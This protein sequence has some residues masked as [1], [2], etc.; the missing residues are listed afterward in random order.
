MVWTVWPC[1]KRTVLG[2]LDLCEGSQAG[3]WQCMV[4]FCC[5]LDDMAGASAAVPA[6]CLVIFFPS[7]TSSLFRI[8]WCFQACQG[9]LDRRLAPIEAW[10]LHL[11]LDFSQRC[12]AVLKLA[13]V[14]ASPC[15]GS[16]GLHSAAGETCYEACGRA[17]CLLLRWL[18]P[19]GFFTDCSMNERALDAKDFDELKI[20]CPQ[21]IL[22]W[23]LVFCD[24]VSNIVR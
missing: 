23:T 12:P 7:H 18:K 5:V 11:S 19:A 14:S 16:E 13:S 4:Y 24:I 20:S 3:V 15:H 2:F 21:F 6:V 8:G 10:K 9:D 22:F 17:V 1:S